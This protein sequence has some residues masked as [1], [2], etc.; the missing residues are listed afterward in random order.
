MPI[1]PRS[2]SARFS[3]R[4]RKPANGLTNR[5]SMLLVLAPIDNANLIMPG[6][7]RSLFD[8]ETGKP[9]W[10]GAG[11]LEMC[12]RRPLD[13]RFLSAQNR[14]TSF[15]KSAGPGTSPRTPKSGDKPVTQGYGGVTFDCGLKQDRQADSNLP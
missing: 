11:C 13:A 14:R 12:R 7:R 8:A 3:V 1:S 10:S 5:N 15:P 2:D 6:G 9:I 4:W